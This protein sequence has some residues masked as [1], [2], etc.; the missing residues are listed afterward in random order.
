MY[1]KLIKETKEEIV[2]N[3]DYPFYTYISLSN[4]CNANCVFCD[5]K[6][7]KDK[8]CAINI[9]ELIDELS[10]MGT[11]YIHFTGGGEPFIN[12]DIMMYIKY[13]TKKD[14]NVNIIS[15]GL[16]ITEEKIKNLKD[17]KINAVFFSI[18]SHI[19]SIH[20][21]LR[22]IDGLWDKV[23]SN[24]N[25]V[26]KYLPKVKI[27]LN[28]VLNKE[29]I[30]DFDKYISM[31]DIFDFDYINP[32]IIKDC[33]QLFFSNDQ[34]ENYN[35]NLEFYY[36]LAKSKNIQFFADN[37]DFFNKKVSNN[38]DRDVNT[39][40]RC[41]YPTLCA[42]VD[43][44]SGGVYPCDCSIHRD[45]EIFKIGNLKEEK[46]IDIWNGYKRLSLKEKLLNSEL[47]C[48]LKCD[49]ANCKFNDYIL[50]SDFK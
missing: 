12:D 19:S 44:P 33:K 7:N 14:I 5:V 2:K 9:Y 23:T 3:K 42:F 38:G 16:N 17:E 1:L 25:L 24:I 43:A 28:H 27:V 21:K 34:I 20:D 18:D 22:G 29:N 48:K 46:F 36:K 50:G 49:E 35:K 45:K 4:I 37:I 8:K 32:I 31:K 40:M 13:C 41:I 30:S 6:Q 11:K 15:N 47:N 26:K 39:T 10:N